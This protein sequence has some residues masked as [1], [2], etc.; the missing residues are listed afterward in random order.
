MEHPSS[1]LR[2]AGWII[3]PEL[4][5]SL[6][7]YLISSTIPALKIFVKGLVRKNKSAYNRCMRRRENFF[8]TFF[9]FLI[10]SFFIFVFAKAGLLGG[11][12]SAL[13][14]VLVPIAS[15]VNQ[16]TRSIPATLNDSAL[17]KLKKENSQLLT[18]L[19]EKKNL[20]TEVVALRDQFQ[21][22]Y[23]KSTDL[24]PAKI[25]ASPSFLPGVSE[26][27][28]F[29]LNRGLKDKVKVGQ[30]V[31]YKNNLVGKIVSVSQ[32]LSDVALAT[33]LDISL[34]VRTVSANNSSALGVVRGTG[35]EMVIE[36][37]LLSEKISPSDL[38]VTKGD[39]NAGGVGLPEDLIA[40]KI[41]AV[42]KKPSA[43]FQT[44]KVKSLL[45]FQKLTVVFLLM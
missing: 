25:I 42:E 37:V 41:V 19:A 35:G 22:P 28:H 44:A 13:E 40:G 39:L 29:I 32:N 26:P 34:T 10:L 7:I 36:N 45:D 43:L 33:S 1:S 2:V 15:F 6:L 18:Q 3:E 31:V 38:V 20:E 12:R 9:F 8:L 21:T 4:S 17:E 24:L 16:I 14:T 11:V 5:P 27:S 30:A 23:P